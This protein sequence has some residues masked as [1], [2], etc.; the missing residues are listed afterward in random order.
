MTGKTELALRPP[1]AA[2]AAYVQP[3]CTFTYRYNDIQYL[4]V[5]QGLFPPGDQHF[6]NGKMRLY[7]HQECSYV[8]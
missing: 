4:G 6:K 3:V 7:G 8:L 5:H 2:A 1:E